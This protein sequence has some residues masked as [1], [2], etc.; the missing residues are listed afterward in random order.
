[1]T[2]SS[3]LSF[4]A[5]TAHLGKMVRLVRRSKEWRV[6]LYNSNIMSEDGVLGGGGVAR[7]GGVT[8]DGGLLLAAA[9]IGKGLGRVA[10][11]SSNKFLAR[12]T[13]GNVLLKAD[14]PD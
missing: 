9:D 12:M 10:I 2:H 4:S 13:L 8:G 11:K 14:P 7:D 3:L 6:W 5:F 1:M